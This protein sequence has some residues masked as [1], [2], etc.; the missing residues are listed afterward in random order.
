MK[1][2]GHVRIVP[3]NDLTKPEIV[4]LQRVVALINGIELLREPDQPLNFFLPGQGFQQTVVSWEVVKCDGLLTVEHR[5]EANMVTAVVS[6]HHKPKPVLQRGRRGKIPRIFDP[7]FPHYVPY[8]MIDP[9]LI[10]QAVHQVQAAQA[11][12]KTPPSFTARTVPVEI[13]QH[14]TA[15]GGPDGKERIC[16]I[17]SV[18]GYTPVTEGFK[19]SYPVIIKSINEYMDEDHRTEKCDPMPEPDIM[20]AVPA[21][22]QNPKNRCDQ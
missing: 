8:I 19:P 15:D 20:R 3:S 12:A 2:K 14:E 6:C 16:H 11:E 22:G 9:G 13:D 7:L 1:N 17:N 21:L 5:P 18:K 4:E 10:G